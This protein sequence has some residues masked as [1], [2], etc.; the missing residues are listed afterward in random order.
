LESESENESEDFC[1]EETEDA[2]SNQ[3]L[4]LAIEYYLISSK[5]KDKVSSSNLPALPNVQ[6]ELLGAK[7][8]Y[9]GVENIVLF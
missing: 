5:T 8:V 9:I 2:M 4:N 6:N 1:S 7:I 3:C